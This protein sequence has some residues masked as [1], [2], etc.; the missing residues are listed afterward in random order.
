MKNK[1]IVP[2]GLVLL[3]WISGSC[4]SGAID[5][6]DFCDELSDALAKND[7]VRLIELRKSTLAGLY[8]DEKSAND[9][10]DAILKSVADSSMTIKALAILMTS[11]DCAMA[12]D[13]FFDNPSTELASKLKDGY[14]LLK[15]TDEFPGFQEELVKKFESMSA[16]DKA[17]ALVSFA[18]PEQIASNMTA[19]DKEL[20]DEVRQL[21]TGDN[22]TRF[23]KALTET[24][25]H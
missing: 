8:G 15:A 11:K 21:L 18:T 24:F 19:S 12:A 3:S 6:S 20:C 16:K 2:I 9:E 1:L 10:V 4:S 25:Q 13:R 23:D 22:L 7:T 17:K 14:G 5:T